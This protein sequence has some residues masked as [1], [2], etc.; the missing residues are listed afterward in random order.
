LFPTGIDL[1]RQVITLVGMN[2]IAY[3]L[4]H[5]LVTK[6]LMKEGA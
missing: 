3:A 6:K 5:F 4:C 2:I 1:G